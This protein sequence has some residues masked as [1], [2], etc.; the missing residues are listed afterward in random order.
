MANKSASAVG[1]LQNDARSLAIN[2]LNICQKGMS[3]QEA[4]DL[5]LAKPGVQ[6]REKAL[7]T[8]LFY[9]SLRADLRIEYILS[10]F[11]KN[12][13]KLPPS[14]ISILKLALYSLLF[15]TRQ[16]EYAPVSWAVETVGKVFGKPLAGLANAVLRNFLRT[17]EAPRRLDFYKKPSDIDE[18][19]AQARFYSLPFWLAAFWRESYPGHYLNLMQRSFQRPPPAFRLNRQKAEA[20]LLA[21]D[22]TRAGLEHVLP[23]A[24]SSANCPLPYPFNAKGIQEL[25]RQG[26]LSW[27]AAG[28]QMVMS[29]LFTEI[30]GAPIWDACAGV[31]GKSLWL[32]ENG[33]DCSLASDI[34]EKRLSMISSECMRLDL[35][36]PTLFVG[37]PEAIFAWEGH[38]LIDAP[39]SGLGVL[40]RRPDI[41]MHAT[42]EGSGILKKHL[43][44]QRHLLDRSA[45][46]IS[47]GFNIIY[48]T[49]TLNHFENEDQVQSFLARHPDFSLLK[50]WQSSTGH[51]WIEGMFGAV[52]QKK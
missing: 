8:E 50:V 25:H 36:R 42:K 34:S 46:I 38:I 28:S 29:E 5:T 13:G 22:A 3:A 37:S 19:A 47:P 26:L 31:G 32:L 33:F 6:D 35:N 20:A 4:L 24:F 30:S 41:L 23:W 48:I 49:C 14:M 45:K 7:C 17:G 43:A 39:C 40:A 2:A 21:A 12:P 15:L 1:R 51:P 44:Q 10:V 18:L 16:P 9:G 11:L 52:L 27:Q